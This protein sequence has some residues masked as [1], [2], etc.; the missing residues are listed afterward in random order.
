MIFLGNR[1]DVAQ[2]VGEVLLYLELDYQLITIIPQE[3]SGVCCV[4]IAIDM[5][6]EDIVE[7]KARCCS[8]TRIT[9][10][11]QNTQG[12]SYPEEE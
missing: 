8:L 11:L 5:S 4:I 10:S 7:T 6:W 3:K 2:F 1:E 9:T 12:M